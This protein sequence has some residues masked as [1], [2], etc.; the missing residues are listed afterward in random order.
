MELA[1]LATSSTT[2]ASTATTQL[3]QNLDTFLTLLTTQLQ[4]Q[5]PLD[6]LDTEQFT[7][8]LVQ[9]SNV[10]Q[11]IETNALL[12]ELIALQ[13]GGVTSSAITTIGNIAS[14]DFST[15]TFNG[16][17]VQWNVTVGETTGGVN[18]E[19]VDDS[20]AVIQR[21]PI[22]PIDGEATIIWRGETLNGNLASNGVYSLRLSG[23]ESNA[24]PID[25]TIRR[26]GI[27][28]GVD[29]DNDEVFLT[30]GSERFAFS[31]LS[32]VTAAPRTIGEN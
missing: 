31:Q 17:P 19:I 16:E 29:F 4:N 26:S 30:I 24:S 20:G 15:A 3:S 13:S 12:S 14:F 22:A 11:N 10:E 28:D 2:R 8:Q 25:A 32:S 23:D 7:E 9:F 1:E 5:D 21:L 27:V 6:P 18:A